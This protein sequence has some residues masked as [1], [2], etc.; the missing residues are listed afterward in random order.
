MAANKYLNSESGEIVQKQANDTSA[1]AGDAGK[2]VALDTAGLLSAT[3]LPAGVGVLVKNVVTSESLAAR[4]MVNLY[5]NAGTLNARKADADNGMPVH[6]Y[7]KAAVTSPAAA[8]VYF[9]GIIAG[10]TSLT[11]G[12]RY[13]L[14]ATAGAVTV[15]PPSGSTNLVQYIGIAISATEIEFDPDD[16]I[17]LAA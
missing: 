8:D 2:L 1:G 10:F 11:P 13:F 15:T 6:G 5:N 12:A 4:D 16:Y 7:V 17:K 9:D 14:S 3:M